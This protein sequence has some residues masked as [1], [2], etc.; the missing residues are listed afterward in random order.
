MKKIGAWIYDPSAR[1]FGKKSQ[2]SILWTTYCSNPEGCDV[3]K[4]GSCLVYSGSLH[5][6]FGKRTGSSGFT[7]KSLKYSNQIRKWKEENP[8]LLDKL[9]TL[10]AT[11]RIFKIQDHYYLPYD[12]MAKGVWG[13]RYPIDSEWIPEADLEAELLDKICTARPHSAFGGELTD[14]QKNSVPKF[15]SDLKSYYPELFELLSDTQK[16]RVVSYVGRVADISTCNPGNYRFGNSVWSWDGEFLTT[17][18]I[19]LPPCKGKCEV[20]LTPD[21]GQPVTITG[22]AQ[23]GENTVFLD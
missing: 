12:F 7:Q 18:S 2:K 1:L 23:V 3:F 17:N 22:D 9:T 14:Y 20:K 19:F 16:S 5:C 6:K 13:S 11:K 8:D 10:K 21:P 15:I 4:T